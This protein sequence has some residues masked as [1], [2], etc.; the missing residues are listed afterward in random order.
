MPTTK[1]ILD[2]MTDMQ[3]DLM[4]RTNLLSKFD[5]KKAWGN[6]TDDIKTKT[7][8]SKGK[9]KKT[10]KGEQRKPIENG[11][12]DTA[13]QGNYSSHFDMGHKQSDDKRPVYQERPSHP[14]TSRGVFDGDEREKE[15]IQR[16]MEKMER[17]LKNTQNK[18]QEAEKDNEYWMDRMSKVT[19]DRLTRD[20]PDIADLSDPKRPQKLGEQYSILYDDEWTDAIEILTE[21]K[22]KVTERDGIDILVSILKGSYEKCVEIADDQFTK[23]QAVLLQ[24][25]NSKD[26]TNDIKCP[27]EVQRSLKDAQK[28]ASGQNLSVVQK[29][30]KK[31]L[32]LPEGFVK[33]PMDEL[34]DFVDK[35][36]DICWAMVMQSPRMEFEYP[37]CKKGEKFN[38]DHFKEFT[39]SGDRLDY[40]VWPAMVTHRQGSLLVKGT[41]QPITKN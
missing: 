31:E 8:A 38:K 26:Q 17:E 41:V 20:N 28:L 27:I 5:S 36:T 33:L 24:N 29:K 22:G 7:G 30:V 13:A 37:E 23:M 10:D 16:K 3:A 35:C 21:N 39:K 12:A 6:L 1:E 14:N 19:G 15:V 40:L 9:E 2:I 11:Y 18:L 25:E 4:K 34:E 32:K